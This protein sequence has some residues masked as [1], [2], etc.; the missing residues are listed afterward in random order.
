[1]TAFYIWL[2][3]AFTLFILEILISST[4][5]LLCFSAGALVAA[6]VGLMGLGT[7]W[8]L[9]AFAIASL[10]AFLF[11]RPVLMKH[12]NERS[13]N[14]PKTNADALIGKTAKVVKTIEADGMG[15]VTIDGDNWQA[16]TECG[17]TIKVGELVE[18]ERIDSIILYVKPKN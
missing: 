13:K 12:I 3:I 2:G 10:F 1:M 4:F 17:E 14:L 7:V 6:F 18:V 11:A 15:R 5:A 16:R 9:I 8:Q